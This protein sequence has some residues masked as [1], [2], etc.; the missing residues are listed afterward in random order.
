MRTS[1]QKSRPQAFCI[2]AITKTSI[3]HWPSD[4]A[5]E[6]LH[7][8]GYLV[9]VAVLDSKILNGGPRTTG[10]AVDQGC[11][12]Y[13]KNLI[14]TDCS[15]TDINS[16]TGTASVCSGNSLHIEPGSPWENGNRER[17]AGGL[18]APVF[19]PIKCHKHRCDINSLTHLGAKTPSG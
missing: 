18:L 14:S 3:R 6:T 8:Y 12:L 5:V 7:V 1:R 10:I 17:F 16:G 4:N 2:I 15:P 19:S 11:A 9:T 13:L